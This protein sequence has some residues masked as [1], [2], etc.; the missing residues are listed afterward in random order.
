MGIKF[1][2]HQEVPQD[3]VHAKAS[4]MDFNFPEKKA[5]NFLS[6]V[7][8]LMSKSVFHGVVPLHVER[9]WDCKKTS[10]SSL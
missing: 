2:S 5:G 6:F 8:F 1:A 3:C 4:H 9:T 7:A 10:F